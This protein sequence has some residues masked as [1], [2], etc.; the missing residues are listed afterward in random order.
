[1]TLQ[2][3]I[4]VAYLIEALD[5]LDHTNLTAEEWSRY[6]YRVLRTASRR[7]EDIEDEIAGL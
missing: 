4:L 6:Y 2:Q 3:Q 5:Y 7:A 1:M